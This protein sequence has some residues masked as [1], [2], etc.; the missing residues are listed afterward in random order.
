MVGFGSKPN[1]KVFKDVYQ[2]A[3]SHSD[4]LI[5][6]IENLPLLHDKDP[7]ICVT[8]SLEDETL[9]SSSC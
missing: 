4:V 6:S 7:D 5:I 9:S 2:T 1:L 3:V 8:L